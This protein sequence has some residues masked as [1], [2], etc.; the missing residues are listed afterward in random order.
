MRL[1]LRHPDVASLR[2]YLVD[3]G[4]MERS[5]GIYRLREPGPNE[6]AADRGA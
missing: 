1:A 6:G 5:A 4:F 3:E 2:R